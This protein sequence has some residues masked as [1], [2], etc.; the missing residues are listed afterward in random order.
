[1]TILAS[2]PNKLSNKNNSPL[3]VY[4]LL[5]IYILITNGI[6]F[7]IHYTKYLSVSLLTASLFFF[8]TINLLICMWELCL[9]YHIKLIQNQFKMIKKKNEPRLSVA[10]EFFTSSIEVKEIFDGKFWSNIWIIY[11]LY[12]PCYVSTESFGWSIDVFNGWSTSIPTMIF[13]YSISNDSSFISPTILG[14]IGLC[15]F[16]QEFYGTVVY[17]GSYIINKRY[18]GIS[19]FE[20]ILM[21][22]I[23]S[24]LW[25]IFPLFGMYASIE[26]ITNQSFSIFRR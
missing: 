9:G 8:L 11:A 26:V 6:L 3:K 16:Y 17:F 19:T 20:I 18:K 14:V 2:P 7:G 25:L 10:F 12:D 21:V 5:I 24:G 15:S 4:H 23:P 1:M 13:A 22:I